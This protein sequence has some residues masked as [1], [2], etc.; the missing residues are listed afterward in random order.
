ML[1]TRRLNSKDKVIITASLTGAVTTKKDN[2]NLP[3]Q[4]EEICESALRCYE[5]GAGSGTYSCQRRTRQCEH[6]VRH[7]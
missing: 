3:T 7:L 1:E 2:P 6:A 5:A 4:P